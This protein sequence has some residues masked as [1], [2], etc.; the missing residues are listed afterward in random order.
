MKIA[1]CISYGLNKFPDD[2][3]EQLSKDSF[4]QCRNNI[5]NYIEKNGKF[6]DKYRNVYELSNQFY[7]IQDV[8][9]TRSWRITDYD[10][11]E[12]VQYLDYDVI[13]KN[14]NYC[15]LRD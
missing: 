2:L 9:I 12:C 3:K 11:S 15:E 7:S 10:G 14:L 6:V 4:P 1:L 13:D 5:V 8:D